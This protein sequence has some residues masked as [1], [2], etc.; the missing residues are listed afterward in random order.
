MEIL[1]S[2]EHAYLND[3]YVYPYL[4]DKGFDGK[5]LEYKFDCDCRKYMPSMLLLA[6]KD[7]NIYLSQSLMICNSSHD[8]QADVNAGVKKSIK[9]ETNRENALYEAVKNILL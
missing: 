3:I 8:Y 2:A 5:R 7:W 9:I 1:L 6:A 4:C